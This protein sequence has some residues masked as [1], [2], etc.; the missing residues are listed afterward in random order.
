VLSEGRIPAELRALFEHYRQADPRTATKRWT[1]VLGLLVDASLDELAQTVTHAVAC[2][3]DDP[4]AIALLLR[5][6]RAKPPAALD[7][8]RLPHVA[9]I[10]T[11]SP[12][13]GAY[14]IAGLAEVAP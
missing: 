11:S 2:G 5:H 12:N 6:R 3:T 9:Q 4:D 13:L 7:R 14:A 10:R 1:R 8:A